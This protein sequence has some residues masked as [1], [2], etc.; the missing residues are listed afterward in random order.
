MKDKRINNKR[1]NTC[2]D[3]FTPLQYVPRFI[4]TISLGVLHGIYSRRKSA[5]R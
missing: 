2:P 1:I 3:R 5:D 4:S